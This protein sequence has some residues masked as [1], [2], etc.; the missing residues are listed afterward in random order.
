MFIHNRSTVNVKKISL[1]RGNAILLGD[2]KVKKH[3]T[4]LFR[5]TSEE[6]L[7]ELDSA[8]LGLSR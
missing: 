8:K 2:F 4:I 5:D 1:S 7:Q 3:A 6:M